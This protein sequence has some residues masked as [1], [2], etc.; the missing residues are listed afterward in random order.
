MEDLDVNAILEEFELPLDSDADDLLGDEDELWEPDD[1]IQSNQA[2]QNEDVTDA[3]NIE[4]INSNTNAHLGSINNRQ[5]VWLV[6]DNDLSVNAPKFTGKEKCHISGEMPIDFFKYMFPD[7]YLQTIVEQSNLYA[8][9]NGKENFNLSIDEL[10]VFIGI[11]FV[12][13][14]L[15]YSRLRQ[16]WSPKHGMRMSL[17]ADNMSYARFC[18]IRRYLHFVDNDKNDSTDKLQKLRPVLDHLKQV[19]RN[20]ID[21]N[22][23]LSIDEM[24]IPFKGKSAVKQYIRGKPHPWGYKVWV[25]A[26]SFGYVLDFEVYQGKSSVRPDPSELGIIGD[27]VMRLSESVRDKYHKLFF[28]NLFTSIPLLTALKEVKIFSSGTIRTNR[29]AGAEKKLVP[30]TELK[31]KPR[32]SSSVVTSQTTNISIV[33]W[34]DNSPVHT[35]SVF[36][37]AEPVGTVERWNNKDKIYEII[38]RP[39]SIELYNKHM[40]GVDLMDSLVGLYR[41]TIKDKR[42]YMRIFY[43]FCQVSVV[44]CWLLWKNNPENEKL[45]LLEFKSSIATSLIYCGASKL[46]K[47]GRPSLEANLSAAKKRAVNKAPSELRLDGGDHYPCKTEGKYAALC[48]LKECRRK[49]RYKCMRCNEPLCPECFF[50]FHTRKI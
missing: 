43:H 15:R 34:F 50:Q 17:V 27:L 18:A 24:I 47:R 13:T 49:T 36:A 25:L 10:K 23:H 7:N 37:G 5:H 8:V 3:G 9:Q 6:K 39:Y 44:N 29:L 40:G 45:D 21:P 22:E 2:G 41:H 46:K 14:Y 12:T 30:A 32:G 4:S 1:I 38:P 20:A 31:K 48:H 16:Y 35:A 28:D 11:N 33:R 19:F 42:W 26:T